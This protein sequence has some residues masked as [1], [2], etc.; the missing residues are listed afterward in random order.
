M[1][2]EKIAKNVAQVIIFAKLNTELFPR[3]KDHP[4]V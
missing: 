2:C 3:K 4:P 1:C